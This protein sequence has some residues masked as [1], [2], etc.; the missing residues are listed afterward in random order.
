MKSTPGSRVL[1]PGEVK[2]QT[3][4]KSKD[5]LSYR[6]NR[7]RERLVKHET[8]IKLYWSIVTMDHS[9]KHTQIRPLIPC[10]SSAFLF[11]IINRARVE[12]GKS[13]TVVRICSLL[14]SNNPLAGAAGR[15]R[16]GS[17]VGVRLP[18]AC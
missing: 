16:G 6:G 18:E 12:L 15:G 17:A 9:H 5:Q 7:K 13:S 8:P 2:A 10:P 4:V 1:G 11:S 3:L 14:S